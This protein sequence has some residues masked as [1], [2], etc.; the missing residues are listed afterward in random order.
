M[1]HAVIKVNENHSLAMVCLHSAGS[2]LG[3]P[4]SGD[5][6]ALEWQHIKHHGVTA[7]QGLQAHY[8]HRHA[9]HMHA[10]IGKLAVIV[11]LLQSILDRS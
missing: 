11:L 9:K 5:L 10:A 1:Q 8:I 2:E 4:S 3:E 7:Y 6:A